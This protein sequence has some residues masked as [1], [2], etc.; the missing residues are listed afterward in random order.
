VIRL[1]R[2]SCP[3]PAALADGDYRNQINKAALLDSTHD[4]CMYCESK[5]THIDYGDIEHFRP[6]VRYRELEFEWSNLGI[7]CAR[8]N[9]SYKIDKFDENTPFIDPYGEDPEV[10]IVAV[11][12]FLVHKR[13]SERGELTIK[14]I[15]LNRGEL[16][17]KRATRKDEIEKEIDRCMRTRNDV[18]RNKALTAL[19]E[20]QAADKE[21]SSV[22]KSIFLLHEID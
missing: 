7:A 3:N 16:I 22:V 9:R 1:E 5:I 20:Q 4:K 2:P 14:D 21:Y 10:H 15:G 17:E 13:G 12:A 19:K 6:K 18:L 11:G 8:C